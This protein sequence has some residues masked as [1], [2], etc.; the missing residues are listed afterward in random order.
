MSVEE[1]RA[2]EGEAVRRCL[3]RA[4]KQCSFIE[5]RN[6]KVIYRRYASLFFLIGVDG[7][8]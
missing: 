7:D 6:F 1:R 5:H 3:A 4:E 2:L 8:E